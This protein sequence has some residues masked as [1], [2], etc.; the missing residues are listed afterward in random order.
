MNKIDGTSA[1]ASVVNPRKLPKLKTTQSECWMKMQCVFFFVLCLQTFFFGNRIRQW[2]YTSAAAE[3]LLQEDSSWSLST[4][5][6]TA[7]LPATPCPAAGRSSPRPEVRQKRTKSQ[8]IDPE[9][10][11]RGP[12]CEGNTNLVI[13]S[14]QFR[15]QG[16]FF[17]QIRGRPLPHT[18][19]TPSWSNP[20][21]CDLM[22]NGLFYSFPPCVQNWSRIS[23]TTQS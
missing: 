6:W 3:G 14:C 12:N 17:S 22:V 11:S 2:L 9:L 23:K 20:V 1:S 10:R 15:D 4:H 8:T 7:Q 13:F 16:V 21:C 5:R 18:P 19:H